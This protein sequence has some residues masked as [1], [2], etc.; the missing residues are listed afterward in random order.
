MIL[1]C[2]FFSHFD[3]SELSE[4]ETYLIIPSILQSLASRHQR[5]LVVIVSM[6]KLVHSCCCCHHFSEIM[7]IVGTTCARFN[8]RVRCLQKDYT[9][10]QYWKE[11]LQCIQKGRE[12]E[13]RGINLL[14]VNWIFIRREMIVIPLSLAKKQKQKPK[15]FTPATQNVV[16]GPTASPESLLEM[17]NL[18]LY[19]NPPKSGRSKER[20]LPEFPDGKYFRLP[21]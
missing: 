2:T 21:V 5:D 1:R 7:R 19:H 20:I 14:F 11:N 3:M 8:C 13:Q 17:Q 18:R 6:C 10:I 12:T 15:C 4:I 16:H 9:M